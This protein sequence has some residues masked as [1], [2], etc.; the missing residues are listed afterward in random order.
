MHGTG[1][2]SSLSCNNFNNRLAAADKKAQCGLTGPRGDLE[3]SAE[4][5]GKKGCCACCMGCIT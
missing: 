3:G 5:G 1:D 4:V 2:F